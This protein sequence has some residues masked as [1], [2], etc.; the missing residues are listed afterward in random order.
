[1]TVWGSA[2]SNLIGVK[3]VHFKDMKKV[4]FPNVVDIGKIFIP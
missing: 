2:E 1:M 3:T 4:S